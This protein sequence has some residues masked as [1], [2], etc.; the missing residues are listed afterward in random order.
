MV[1]YAQPS[2]SNSA[3]ASGATWLRSLTVMIDFTSPIVSCT[4]VSLKE[5][6]A[7][8][9]MSTSGTAGLSG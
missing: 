9:L 5:E 8:E 3:S 6:A 7:D 1:R 2:P 4:V